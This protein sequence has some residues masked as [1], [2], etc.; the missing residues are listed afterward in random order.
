[1]S[2]HSI[3]ALWLGGL[4]LACQAAGQVAWNGRVVDENDAPLAGARVRV[5]QEALAPIEA[6]SSPTGSFVITVPAPGRY[7]VT[8][9]RAG[10]FQ[11]RNQPV[12]IAAGAAETTLVLNVQE[13]VFQSIHVGAL[14]NPVDASATGGEERLSGTEINDVPYPATE[15]LRNGMRLIPGMIEDPSAGLHFHGA[16][17]YQTQ[18]LLDGVNI[19]DPINGHYSTPLA[20]D[21]VQSVDLEG[22][23][24]SAQYGPGSGGT[25]AIQSES[26]TDQ[27]RYTI[28]NFIPGVDQRG[29]TRIGDWAPRG[30]IS[31]PI[32]KGSAWFAD[33][34]NGN[35]NNGYVA[36]LPPD[37]DTN[38]AWA[39]GNLA[40][41]QANLSPAN[42]FYADL[43]TN[44][45]HQSHFGLG[46]LDPESTSSG[47]SDR[48]WMLSAKD[49]HSWYDGS[50]VEVGMAWQAVYHRQVPE[51]TAPY[52]VT[53]EGRS[54]NYFVDSRQ[55]GS[56][57][58]AFITYFP[59]ARTLR[60]R[61]QLQTGATA[62]RLDYDARFARTENEVIGLSGLPEFVT[63]FRGSGEF[64]RGNKAASAYVND[65]WQ[66]G[67]RVTVDAGARLDW[68]AM[69]GAAA[70]S[71]RIAV[72]WAPMANSRTKLTAGY[73]ILRDPTNLALFSE[74]LDQQPVTT[75]YNS[76]G[77]P[78]A[79]LVTTFLPGRDLTFPRYGQW[80]AGAARELGR[81]VLASAEWL[82][83]RGSDGFAYAQAGP[84]TPVNFDLVSLAGGYGGDYYMSNLRRD[85]YDEVTVTVRQSF[86]EQYGWM[87]SYT[88]SRAVSN[89]VLSTTIDEPLQVTGDFTPMPWDAP[90]RLLG[91]GYFPIHGPNWALAMLADYRTGLPYSI[92]ADSGVLVGP[93]NAQRYPDAFDLNVHVE[94]RFVFRGYRLGLRLGCNNITGHANYT[95]VNNVEGAPNFEQFYGAEG[96]R[97]VVRIRMFGRVKKP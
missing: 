16:A 39:L 58:Q 64:D 97:V 86:G 18:Y 92:T 46:P 20:V 89:A 10:Y 14:P 25:L 29:G 7:L 63:T 5:R 12:E 37:A 60:G 81:H 44:F 50:L 32:V 70:I 47:R 85:D 71:P 48:E 21:G 79:P 41:A 76:S 83:K 75:P 6:E 67:G 24:Q 62:Q 38:A 73:A 52:L 43:L 96:R 17:E 13:E 68:D 55:N 36:G 27:Y 49:S 91:W 87:T 53:P 30:V 26:G 40:H 61:H 90:N 45:D 78:L 23:R 1:M 4:A 93:L 69:L 94:R 34:V 28:T 54:G 88:R 77:V 95:A 22:T 42:I 84:P 35:Y 57:G 51:G 82:R 59:R 80:S 66:P 31:G 56:R 65:H 72:A 3:V 8:V 2:L 19:T 74:P 33:S 11:L 9:D 15:S